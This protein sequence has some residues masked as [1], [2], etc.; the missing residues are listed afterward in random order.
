M[1]DTSEIEDFRGNCCDSERIKES[2]RTIPV[3]EPTWFNDVGV[4]EEGREFAEAKAKSSL[5]DSIIRSFGLRSDDIEDED[6]GFDKRRN[7]REDVDS[8]FKC[9]FEAA[10][11]GGELLLGA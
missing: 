10:M 11:V 8:G 3:L 4:A 1:G 2:F 7:L 6:G 9:K 5:D